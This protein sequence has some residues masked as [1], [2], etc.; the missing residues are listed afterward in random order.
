[1]L[2]SVRGLRLNV[3]DAGSGDPPLLFIHGNGG[4]TTN[5]APQLERFSAKHRVIALDLRGFGRSDRTL[6]DISLR[7]YAED[8]EAI[9]AK[10]G[11][12]GCVVVG[13]SLGG[14]VAQELA[15]LAPRRVAG[16]LL[17]DSASGVDE[18]M[19]GM[20]QNAARFALEGGMEPM[21]E[22]YLGALFSP[23]TLSDNQAAVRHFMDQFTTGDPL[24]HYLANL[25]VRE[26][27]LVPRLKKIKVPTVVLCGEHDQI[28][29]PALSEQTHRAIAGSKLVIVPDAAHVS[30]LEQ[31]E[32]FN[33]E[34]DGLIRSVRAASKK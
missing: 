16:L 15:L 5:W 11:V 34:L 7:D 18:E 33:K 3:V 12:S 14:M 24:Q 17:A 29:P 2:V 21:A 13:L 20:L 32:R 6:G 27:N 1:L 25:A 23:K 31:P 9:M 10:L 4:D 28:L 8:V 26:M 30:N 22:A 19:R